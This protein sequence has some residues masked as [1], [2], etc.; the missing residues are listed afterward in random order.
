MAVDPSARSWKAGLPWS[1]ADS[2]AGWLSKLGGT[3][4]L[5]DTDVVFKPL[6]HLGLTSGSTD[7]SARDDA[8]RAIAAST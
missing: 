7:T 5:T 6:W 3:L 1:T 8:V 2:F 4:V